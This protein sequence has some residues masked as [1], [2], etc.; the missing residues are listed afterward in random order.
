MAEDERNNFMYIGG[1]NYVVRTAAGTRKAYKAWLKSVEEVEADQ[2]V[3][4][5]TWPTSFPSV[6]RF[7]FHYEGFHY[8]RTSHEHVNA[9]RRRMASILEKLDEIDPISSEADDDKHD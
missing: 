4:R 2:D 7:Y 5:A 1:G 3:S 8:V 9:F 6:I